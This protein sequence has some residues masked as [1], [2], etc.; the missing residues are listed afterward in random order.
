MIA[1]LAEFRPAVE[2]GQGGNPDLTL[3]ERP[4]IVEVVRRTDHAAARIDERIR[5]LVIHRFR[6]VEKEDRLIVPQTFR[7]AIEN[8]DG[9]DKREF[10]GR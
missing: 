3:P 8:A 5:F 1:F 4:G 9:F 7:I 10:A 6:V 2:V